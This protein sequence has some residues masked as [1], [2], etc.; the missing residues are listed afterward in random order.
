MNSRVLSHLVRALVSSVKTFDMK[1]L[2]LPRGNGG[3]H[4]A[5]SPTGFLEL[6][7]RMELVGFDFG[8][9]SSSSSQTLSSRRWG[10]PRPGDS[11][12]NQLA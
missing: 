2:K 9:T 1:M 4:L 5:I 10:Q 7:S 8:A 6:L 12:M 3:F 11:E